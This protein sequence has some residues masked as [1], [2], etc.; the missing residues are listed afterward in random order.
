[1]TSPVYGYVHFVN[2]IK[3]NNHHFIGYIAA[4]AS[5]VQ[6]FPKSLYACRTSQS[7]TRYLHC[8]AS[9][10]AIKWHYPN[11]TV[12]TSTHTTT[13]TLQGN[14]NQCLYIYIYIYIYIYVP[15]VLIIN[16]LIVHILY[17]CTLYF[18]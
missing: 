16:I 15:V 14:D 1:M 7:C 4:K 5:E 11:S 12:I 8:V 9:Q 13:K 6:V 3:L 10:R 17:P 18:S 2:M